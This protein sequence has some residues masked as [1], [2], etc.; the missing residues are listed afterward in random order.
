MKKPP[1]GKEK[2]GNK[3]PK[4]DTK[5]DSFKLYKEGKSVQDIANERGLTVQTIE[6]HLTHY[7]Q[8]GKI[9]INDLVSREKIVLIEPVL[10]TFQGGSITSI[11]EKLGG[12]ISF[13]EIKLVLAWLAFQKSSSSHIDH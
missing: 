13:G 10:K 5:L 2:N 9:K 4:T 8:S 7:V 6:G 3:K 1:S 12:G 11:K